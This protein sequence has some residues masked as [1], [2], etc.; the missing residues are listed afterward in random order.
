M[1]I[2]DDLVFAHELIAIASEIALE[3][4]RAGL[5]V[6]TK[7]DGTL[8]TEADEAIERELMQRIQ[9]AHPA[10][11]ILGEE[12][13]SFGAASRRWIV[14]PIDGTANFASGAQAWGTHVALESEG[15]IVLGIISRPELSRSW[16]ATRG[17][18]AFRTDWESSSTVAIA[19]SDVADLGESRVSIW[20][21]Q[22]NELTSRIEKDVVVNLDADLN[23]ILELAEGKLEAVVDPTGKPWDHAPAVLLVEEAGGRFSDYRGG[24]RIDIGEI[25]FTNGII[26][27][28]FVDLLDR[29]R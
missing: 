13:G 27:E 25:R 29:D 2:E 17:G 28:G 26:H 11:S 10:D 19:V 21:E 22:P 24:K 5:L 1:E 12:F 4:Q 18:G 23:S 15:Q 7:A 3:H 20:M 9:K 16:W 8:V 6:R 14:D